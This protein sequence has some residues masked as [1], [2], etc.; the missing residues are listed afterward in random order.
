MLDYRGS[1]GQA[2]VSSSQLPA[3][4]AA[5]CYP[6]P[7][8]MLAGAGSSPVLLLRVISPCIHGK[9]KVIDR[10]GAVDACVRRLPSGLNGL[11]G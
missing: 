9:A 6:V 4:S 10:A 2:Q 11:V 7:S 1:C 8:A 5:Q 3:A